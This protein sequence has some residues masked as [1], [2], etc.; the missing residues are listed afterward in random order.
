MGT[1]WGGTDCGVKSNSGAPG[2]FCNA[3]CSRPPCCT[4]N[5]TLTKGLSLNADVEFALDEGSRVRPDILVLSGSRA[6]T[7]NPN[8]VPVPGAPDLAVEIIS[9]SERSADTQAKL[10]TYLRAGSKEVW[11]V[12]PKSRPV[13]VHRAGNSTILTGDQ[14]LGTPLLEG[15]SIKV[16]SLF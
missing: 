6:K 10:Q 7:L 9:P 16:Q 15:F 1:D 13:V 14:T 12:Y 3:F 2:S 4:F 5:R 8:Q 11:H